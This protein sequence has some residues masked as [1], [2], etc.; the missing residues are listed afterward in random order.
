MRYDIIGFRMHIVSLK[1]RVLKFGLMMKRGS[2]IDNP[3]KLK[4]DQSFGTHQKGALMGGGSICSDPDIECTPWPIAIENKTLQAE[5]H[6]KKAAVSWSEQQ[7][8]G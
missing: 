5:H 4:M 6:K 3:G 7:Q 2:Y 8:P 1:N